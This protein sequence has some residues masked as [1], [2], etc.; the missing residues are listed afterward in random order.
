MT[1]PNVFLAKSQQGV[2]G[3]GSCLLFPFP[4]PLVES[5]KGL[6]AGRNPGH[7]FLRAFIR[8]SLGF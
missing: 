5:G 3:W 6:T 7:L 4:P 2:M 8:F 1:Q